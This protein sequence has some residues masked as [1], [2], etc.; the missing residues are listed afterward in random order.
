MTKCLTCRITSSQPTIAS[1][2]TDRAVADELQR[3]GLKISDV[4]AVNGSPQSPRIA[5]LHRALRL[6]VVT[7]MPLVA[8][9]LDQV[10]Q[11]QVLPTASSQ[12]SVIAL[13]TGN[14]WVAT[15]ALDH[16]GAMRELSHSAGLTSTCHTSQVHCQLDSLGRW[17]HGTLANTEGRDSCRQGEGVCDFK[18][19]MP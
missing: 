5:S 9:S 7:L 11:V 12:D 10:G 4:L 6:H 1:A 16:H 13:A 8:R 14:E 17:Q 2:A 19:S 18:L 3:R 15:L